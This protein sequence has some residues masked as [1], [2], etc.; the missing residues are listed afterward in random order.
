MK[1]DIRVKVSVLLPTYNG[2]QFIVRAIKS[3]LAQTFQDFELLVID[4]G[5]TDDTATQVEGVAARDSRV[6]FIR[7][8]RNLGLQKTLNAGL[9]QARGEYIA[10]IDDD[11][12]WADQGKLAAQVAFLDAN[13]KTVLVGTGV[14]V[15]SESGEELLR[16]LNPE[17]DEQIRHQL[18]SRNCFS[19]SSVVFRTAAV[20]SLGGYGENVDVLHIEDYDLWLRLGGVGQLTNLPRYDIN[21]TS[22][23]AA[24]SAQNRSAQFK[25]TIALIKKYRQRYPRYYRGLVLAYARYY[26]YNL[27]QL[28]PASMRHAFLRAYKQH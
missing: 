13:Q 12:T 14:V 17:T 26:F 6:R 2:G 7:N 11:D 27:Y 10:R 18:L 25:R 8:E 24:V 19:H 22:R 20:R 16:F 9:Q 28:M 3:V 1:N 21:F 5:S 23:K 15:V 4:D